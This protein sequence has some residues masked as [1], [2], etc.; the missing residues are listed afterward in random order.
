MRCKTAASKLPYRARVC[1][2][3]CASSSLPVQIIS[4]IRA[5][6]KAEE[7]DCGSVMM[8][9]PGPLSLAPLMAYYRFGIPSKN[10][11]ALAPLVQQACF[12][13]FGQ[14]GLVELRCSV[15]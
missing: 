4:Q 15:R 10:A 14:I 1:L 9:S 12:I 13:C 6:Y 7:C 3:A 8:W 11:Q 2:L 5:F